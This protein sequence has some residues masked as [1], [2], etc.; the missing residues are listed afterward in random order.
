MSRLKAQ[1]QVTLRISFNPEQS[2][3]E[4]FATPNFT[5][6]NFIW[7]PSQVSVVLPEAV[8]NERLSIRSTSVGSWGDNSVV[9][10]PATTPAADFHGITTSGS[11]LDF[12][13]GTEFLL[14][15]FALKGGYVPDVRLF[16]PV[17]DPGSEQKG[18]QGGDFRSYMSDH[19]GHDYLQIDSQ[20]VVLAV[21]EAAV[22]DAA[23]QVVAYPNP[24][25]SGKFRLYL[26]GFTPS[27]VVRVR[28]V[29][30]TGRVLSTFEEKVESLVDRVIEVNS[31][32]DGYVL[33]NLERL[34]TTQQF[35][36]KLWFR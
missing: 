14:F 19:Q 22:T 7:G 3:Y 21:R 27:E 6:K 29:N 9:Y 26:P 4:V 17:V 8:A 35:T 15:D 32:V 28:L 12:Q 18:M 5:A 25:V 2:R 31:S 16:N 23:M 1:P 30:L 24:S 11:K 33:L 20:R 13:A 36:H 34:T 10:G